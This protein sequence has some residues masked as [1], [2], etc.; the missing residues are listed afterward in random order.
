MC[1]YLPTPLEPPPLPPSLP[2]PH[3]EK[4]DKEN[5]CPKSKFKRICLKESFHRKPFLVF[6]DRSSPRVQYSERR[7]TKEKIKNVSN[8]APP[9]IQIKIHQ[10]LPQGELPQKGERLRKTFLRFY[11]Y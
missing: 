4:E 9:P 1:P 2:L 11:V 10:D 7:K 6:A 3:R 8:S 5:K